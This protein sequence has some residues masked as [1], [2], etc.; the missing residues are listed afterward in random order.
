MGIWKKYVLISKI[1]LLIIL[2]KT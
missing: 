2:P 1:L